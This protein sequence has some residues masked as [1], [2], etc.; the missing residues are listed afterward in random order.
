M[1]SPSF[2]TKKCKGMVTIS[3]SRFYASIHGSR[4][5][6]TRQGTAK[7]GIIGHV[8]G[9]NV[10]AKIVCCVNEDGED[11]VFVYRTSGSNGYGSN[12]IVARFTAD[13]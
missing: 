4:G 13:A 1:T 3:M 9:W 12:E 7:S 2:A 10:G 5:E 8:R 6:A 11:E